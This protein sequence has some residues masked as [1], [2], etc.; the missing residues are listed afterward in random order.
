MG[1][2]IL[3]TRT[4]TMWDSNSNKYADNNNYL[5]C[6]GIQ[7]GGGGG[8]GGGGILLHKATNLA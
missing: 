4:S 6:L 7:R 8:G 1:V 5:H 3:V 2:L